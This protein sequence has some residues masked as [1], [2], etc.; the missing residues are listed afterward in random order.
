MDG[1]VVFGL[2][3]RQGAVYTFGN[4]LSTTAA[5][6]SFVLPTGAGDVTG[7]WLSFTSN[8]GSPADQMYVEIRTNVSSKPGVL[9]ATSTSIT[10]TSNV[11]NLFPF[12]SPVTLTP[13]TKYWI[14]AL[15]VGAL[16]G[17]NY[18]RLLRS[19][20]SVY[21]AGGSSTLNTSSGSV[22]STEAAAN[23]F[24]FGLV[25]EYTSPPL[26]AVTQDTAI[27]VWKSTDDGVTWT[28]QDAAHA[29]AV[30]NAAYPFSAC[31]GYTSAYIYA[32]Y[33]SATN[34]LSRAAF[35]TELDLWNPSGVFTNGGSP[36]TT[37]SNARPIRISTSSNNTTD[38]VGN[39]HAEWTN[40]TNTATLTNMYGSTTN[41]SGTANQLVNSA[42]TGPSIVADAVMDN[43][44]RTQRFFYDFPAADFTVRSM[45]NTTLGT[46]TDLD[47]AV[48]ATAANYLSA[49]YQTYDVSG[50][51]TV[52]AAFI[53]A[54]AS[55]QE[56]IATLS[57]A[58]P[59][60][61]TQR[62]ITATS[63][64]GRMVS[65]CNYGGTL[66][67]FVN[68]GTGIDYY[69][70]APTGS[71]SSVT[72]WKTG[73]TSAALSQALAID[74]LGILV[75]YM[76]NG[77][78]IAEWAVDGPGGAGASATMTKG[79]ATVSGKAVTASASVV[80]TLT[81]KA[82][83]VSGKTVTATGQRNETATL[84]KTTA[85]ATGYGLAGTAGVGA[86]ATMTV[87]SVT[88]TG[89][90][91]SGSASVV[92]AMSAGDAVVAG[93][94]L[95]ASAGQSA[96]ATLTITEVTVEGQVLS[97]SAGASAALSVAEL[98]A[99]GHALTA[100]GQRNESATLDAG[101]VA[102]TGHSLTGTAE[103]ITDAI[104]TLT[105]AS[106]IL[107][108]R[109]LSASAGTSATI[110]HGTAVVTGRA[111]TAIALAFIPPLGDFERIQQEA[112]VRVQRITVS[113][114]VS[115]QRIMVSPP[116]A[117]SRGQSLIPVALA[118]ALAVSPI[119]IAREHEDGPLAIAYNQD[120]PPIATA[121]ERTAR[122]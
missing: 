107:S 24:C 10:P 8:V 93:H 108:G 45:L 39:H 118:R 26:Y 56:R 85:T 4:A 18:Y 102:V 9:I 97:A 30:A 41:W 29:P 37:A 106:V 16:D 47:T 19:S 91:L 51:D 114:A 90:A 33:F 121:R 83:T 22:W 55:L 67:C 52:V 95:S 43:S 1:E 100:T 71:W 116:V 17:S 63:Y 14:T 98:I 120:T 59:T 49:T 25:S 32:L 103:V 86:S 72:N 76:D 113:M 6:Q 64:A 61:T 80:A 15:R 38:P 3:V 110:T 78:V 58:T 112:P 66:Y 94:D 119:A 2:P 73:L 57:K 44:S 40:S 34:T 115:S 42:T 48:N 89:H 28:E 31:R 81:R 75:S 122:T 109:G 117:L 79:T 99:T 7:V 27:H 50:S 68:T 65:T 35:D 84:T 69:T 5:A 101:I 62:Q 54:N 23:D 74:G 87:E 21:A 111:F 82:L 13:G 36:P 53:D 46:A 60:F 105:A 92:A 12:A 11:F 20:S 88:I 70:A 77:N 104:A 96:S